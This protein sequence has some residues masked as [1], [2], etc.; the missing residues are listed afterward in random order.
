MKFSDEMKR[1]FTYQMELQ[2]HG[3]V[4]PPT[5]GDVKDT[6]DELTKGQLVTVCNSQEPALR[7]HLDKELV[8]LEFDYPDEWVAV[9]LGRA[10]PEI[11]LE[12][13]VA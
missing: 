7:K 12:E 1:L 9:M 10:S 11:E 8:N 13:A 4:E 3:G 5:L 2:E 6:L